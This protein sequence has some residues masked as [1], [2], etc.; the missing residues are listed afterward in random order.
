MGNVMSLM[1]AAEFTLSS[2]WT[3]RVEAMGYL[4]VVKSIPGLEHY[5]P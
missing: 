4:D 2:G 5:Y 3:R 1:Q